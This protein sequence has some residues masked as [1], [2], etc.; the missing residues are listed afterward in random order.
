M[1]IPYGLPIGPGPEH[2][3]T[4]Q[5]ERSQLAE[6]RIWWRSLTG[7]CLAI[8]FALVYSTYRYGGFGLLVT[9]V[10]FYMAAVCFSEPSLRLTKRIRFLDYCAAEDQGDHER[11]DPQ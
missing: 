5:S 7:L 9:A 3:K 2:S 8:S 10:A 4:P 6:D 11:L 1:P